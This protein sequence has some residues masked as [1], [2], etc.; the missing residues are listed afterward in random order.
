MGDIANEPDKRKFLDSL[1]YKDETNPVAKTKAKE[2]P[3]DELMPG[4]Y[5]DKDEEKGP[6]SPAQTTK[7]KMDMGTMKDGEIIK[8]GQMTASEFTSKYGKKKKAPSNDPAKTELKQMGKE[9]EGKM[10]KKDG[11]MFDQN[12]GMEAPHEE[13]DQMIHGAEAVAE[14]HEEEAEMS[15]TELIALVVNFLR[16]NGIHMDHGEAPLENPQLE[17]EIEKEPDVEVEGPAEEEMAELVEDPQK[18]Q[19]AE[20]LGKMAMFKYRARFTE[21]RLNI[22]QD[23]ILDYLEF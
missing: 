21:A 8:C 1:N 9:G 13:I 12:G 17:G 4:A 23:N 16:E 5:H 7:E 19:N 3:T 2:K 14:E 11:M 6:K 18:M 15:A 10:L 20:A 22:R